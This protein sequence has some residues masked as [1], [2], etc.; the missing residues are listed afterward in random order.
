M[1]SYP[2]PQVRATA[3]CPV[4]GAVLVVRRCKTA[5]RKKLICDCEC[6]YSAPLPESLRMRL[7][8]WEELP[9]FTKEEE[10]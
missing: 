1:S 4:C 2:P 8:G 6:G 10:R 9:L 5:H 3:P 7:A